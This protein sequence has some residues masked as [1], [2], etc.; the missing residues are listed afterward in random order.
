MKGL[1]KT[2]MEKPHTHNIKP[3]PSFS[4]LVKEKSPFSTPLQRVPSHS[5][6][7]LSKGSEFNTDVTACI[8]KHPDTKVGYNQCFNNLIMMQ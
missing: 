6:E 3:I 5:M 1:I 8:K 7:L 2:A 4:A